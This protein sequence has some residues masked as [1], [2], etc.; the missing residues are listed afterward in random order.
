MRKSQH[1]YV[2]GPRGANIAEIMTE[3]G[4]S[5]EMPSTDSPSETI[6]LRGPPGKLGSG[7]SLGICGKDAYIFI[8][9]NVNVS[10]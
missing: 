9:V 2:I 1:R 8:I 3:T 10:Y 6:T 7:K 5:V 4:V